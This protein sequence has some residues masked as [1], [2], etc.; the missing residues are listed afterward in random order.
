MFKWSCN[1]LG[2][3]TASKKDALFDWHMENAGVKSIDRFGGISALL[4][5]LG[6][7][8]KNVKCCDGCVLPFAKMED[9]F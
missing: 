9:I 2:E 7:D 5:S 1:D 8:P 4:E 6:T 3:P